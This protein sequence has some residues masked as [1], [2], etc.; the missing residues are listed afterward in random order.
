MSPL[1]FGTYISLVELAIR[2]LRQMARGVCGGYRGVSGHP[3]PAPFPRLGKVRP[4]HSAKTV[5]KRVITKCR[6]PIVKS[7]SPRNLSFLSPASPRD[8]N[9]LRAWKRAAAPAHRDSGA[10]PSRGPEPQLRFKFFKRLSEQQGARRMLGQPS[11]MVLSVPVS[12]KLIQVARGG[13]TLVTGL[14]GS[15]SIAETRC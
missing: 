15:L 10:V 6:K 12:G 7:C 4:S 8:G 5:I 3:N 11:A 13:Q 1:Q 14:Y 9:P 2:H